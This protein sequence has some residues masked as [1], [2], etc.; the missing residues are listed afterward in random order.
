MPMAVGGRAERLR[1]S[2]TGNGKF[3]IVLLWYIKDDINILP[4]T[5]PSYFMYYLSQLGI[6]FAKQYTDGG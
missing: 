1:V 5:L 3:Y 2:V 4:C 6:K